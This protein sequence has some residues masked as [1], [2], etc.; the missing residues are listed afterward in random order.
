L[1]LGADDLVVI[2]PTDPEAMTRYADECRTL[3]VPFLF[4]PGKQTP[5]LSGEQILAGLTGA[6]VLIGNDYEFAMMARETGWTEA[7]LIS[8]VPLAVVT[9]GEQ[10]STICSA[11][12]DGQGLEIPVA[13]VTGVVDRRGGCLPGRTGVRAGA[14]VP[15]GGR[16]THRRIGGGLRRRAAG[17]PGAHHYM[18]AEFAQ[19]YADAFGRSPEVEAIAESVTW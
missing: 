3:G 11:E 16:R 8:A 15:S 14:P 19:R 13:P 17:L 4:D 9:R 1:G 2:S 5:R 18:P 12:T 6:S 7:E 10:G